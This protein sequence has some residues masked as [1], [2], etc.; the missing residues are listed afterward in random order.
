MFALFRKSISLAAALVVAA[1]FASLAR[2]ERICVEEVSGVC[3]KYQ[4]VAPTPAPAPAAPAP[5]RVVSPAEQ[6]ER[7]LGL[8]RDGRRTVQRGLAAEGFYNGAID[9]LIGG[10]T[11]SAITAWQRAN[12][13]AASGF[14][15]RDQVARLSRVAARA[16]PAPA[17]ASPSPGAPAPAAPAGSGEPE[18]DFGEVVNNLS[19]QTIVDT[20][21]TSLTFRSNGS[22]LAI[23]EDAAFRVRWTYRNDQFCI[24]SNG[25][26]VKCVPIDVPVTAGN[27]ERIR[28]TIRGSC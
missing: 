6:A 7:S 23:A 3:L 17:P 22:V 26:D 25:R 28:A 4:D 10:G 14:L 20:Y 21:F 24:Q 12:G 8:N 15:D 27:R 19:C 5:A 1:G 18:I 9:G 11:R 2:A 13:L 16:R